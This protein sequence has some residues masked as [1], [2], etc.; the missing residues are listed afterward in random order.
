MHYLT[1]DLKAPI[2]GSE[3]NAPTAKSLNSGYP[4]PIRGLI[5]P[6]SPVHESK[7]I[8]AAL[9]IHRMLQKPSCTFLIASLSVISGLANPLQALSRVSPA[10]PQLLSAANLTTLTKLNVPSP[11]NSALEVHCNRHYGLHPDLVD[12]ENAKEHIL[13]EYGQITWGERHTGQ[14]PSVFPLP[15]RIMGG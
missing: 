15:Y 7:M 14:G 3:A 11:V 1:F 4:K 9:V 13:P 2:I 5:R 12:C 6:P 10:L 8:E